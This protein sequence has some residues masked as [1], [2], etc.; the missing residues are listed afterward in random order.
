MICADCGF[1]ILSLTSG[2][3]RYRETLD[4]NTDTWTVVPVHARHQLILGI[5]QPILSFVSGLL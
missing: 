1:P 5:L 2:D 4:H 3:V